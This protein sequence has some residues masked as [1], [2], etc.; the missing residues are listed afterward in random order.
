M[1]IK[2]FI[3]SFIL[4]TFFNILNQTG[5]SSLNSGPIE[6]KLEEEHRHNN[7]KMFTLTLIK[8]F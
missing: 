2:L 7:R 1:Q 6:K 3:R 5:E 8:L 4:S